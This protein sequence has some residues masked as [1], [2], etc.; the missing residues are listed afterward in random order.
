MTGL[1]DEISWFDWAKVTRIDG[2]YLP[3]LI[4]QGAIYFITF[5]LADSLPQERVRELK[6]IRDGWL[7]ANPPPHTPEQL[8]ELKQVYA[9]PI[10]RYLDDG[11]GTCLLRDCAALDELEHV[12]CYGD[13][14]QYELGDYVIMPNHV[15]VLM[16]PADAKQLLK[17]CKR[18]KRVAAMEINRGRG[19]TGRLWQEESFDHILRGSEY[20]A[21]FRRYIQR[22]PRNLRDGEFRLDCGNAKWCG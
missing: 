8:E 10:E 11:D 12:L 14:D 3:H 6:R 7:R 18:W 4:Q 15:H 17:I 16:R 13:D 19:R 5:R 2:R 22:N 9:A 20:L 21:K 1:P